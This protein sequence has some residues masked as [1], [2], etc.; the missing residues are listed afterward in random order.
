MHHPISLDIITLTL[1]KSFLSLDKIIK[2]PLKHRILMSHLDVIMTN[3]RLKQILALNLLFLQMLISIL[4][5]IIS[6][7]NQTINNIYLFIKFLI[8]LSIDNQLWLSCYLGL[9]WEILVFVFILHSKSLQL[10]ILLFLNHLCAL[11]NRYSITHA[12]MWGE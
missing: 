2:V 1:L 9:K 6:I 8:I 11:I 5:T 12:G 7:F 3:L 4:D 10:L